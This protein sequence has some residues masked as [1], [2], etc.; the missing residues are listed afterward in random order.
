MLY[1]YFSVLVLH[2]FFEPMLHAFST[3]MLHAFSETILH[4][5]IK[6]EDC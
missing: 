3:P 4:A 6:V 2:A 1:V 5:V